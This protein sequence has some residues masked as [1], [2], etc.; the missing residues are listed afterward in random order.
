M[1]TALCLYI[2]ELVRGRDNRSKGGARQSG[3]LWLISTAIASARTMKIIFKY[4]F[5]SRAQNPTSSLYI[6]IK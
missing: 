2:T 6:Q 3:I 4:L 5:E 1:Q